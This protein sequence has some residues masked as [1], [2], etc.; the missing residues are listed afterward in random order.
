MD[1]YFFSWMT[2]YSRLHRRNDASNSDEGRDGKTVAKDVV[3]ERK[4][5]EEAAKE[6][7]VASACLMDR[8]RGIT[9]VRCC[10]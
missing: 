1:R 3:V 2:R 7:T 9:P 4:L 8:V 5:A 10:L 6:W